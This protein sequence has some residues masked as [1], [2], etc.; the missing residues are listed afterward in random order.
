MAFRKTLF[1][2]GG[3]SSSQDSGRNSAGSSEPLS[4][5]LLGIT[6]NPTARWNQELETCLQCLVSQ[7]QASWSRNLVWVE[8]AHNLLPTSATGMS[9]IQCAFGYQPPVFSETEVTVPTAQAMVRRCHRVWAATRKVLLHSVDRM[10]RAADWRR[11]PAP[12]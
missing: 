8:Y 10:K 4:A 2:T 6:Q 11:R 12:A 9:P 3:P 1:Q 7:N 5:S